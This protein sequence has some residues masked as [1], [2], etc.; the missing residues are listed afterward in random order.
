MRVDIMVD[1]ETLGTKSDSTIIQISAIAF[2][3]K[4]GEYFDTFNQI[5]DISKNTLPLKVTGSTLQWWVNTNKELFADIL[6]GGHVSSEQVLRNFNDWITSLHLA[7]V[8]NIFL[9]GN[10]ILFDNVMIRHQFEN[11]DF[12]YPIFYRNDRDLRTLVE[13]ASI[14]LGVTEKA[15]REKHYNQDLI[16]HDAFND[17]KNQINLAVACFNELVG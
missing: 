11:V 14:K 6:N 1:L 17:V 5:A 8:E 7:G 2:D 3:I 15:L 16:A 4:T 9:W 13:L 12:E 10:G